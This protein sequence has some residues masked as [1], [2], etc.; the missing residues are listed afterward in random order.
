M[1]DLVVLKVARPV[2]CVVPGQHFPDTTFLQP[3]CVDRNLGILQTKKPPWN[4]DSRAAKDV[5]KRG[6]Q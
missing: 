3:K 6:L 5:G 1:S 2:G 4:P